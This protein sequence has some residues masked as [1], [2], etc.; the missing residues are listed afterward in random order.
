MK[1]GIRGHDLGKRENGLELAKAAKKANF[2]SMQLVLHKALDGVSGESSTL[3][4]EF[5]NQIK[6]AFEQNNIEIIMLGAYFNIIEG[7]KVQ[8]DID[9]FKEHL[10]LAKEFG[11]SIVG[12]ET[13]SYSN[14]RIYDHRTNTKEAYDTVLKVVREL[15]AVAE[16][17]D[18]YVAIEAAWYH[19]IS[20]CKLVKKLLDDIHSN[21]LKVI[22]DLFNLVN[23]DNYKKQREIIDEAF[24]LYGEKIVLVHAKD[25]VVNG[26]ALKQ[27]PLGE[28]LYDYD[29]LIKK[30]AQEKP[31]M[32]IIFEGI[33]GENKIN[34]SY[35]FIKNKVEK[36]T[37]K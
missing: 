29:Y 33:T 24:D 37:K 9:K 11:C 25:F 20:N 36:Y 1:I 8:A 4:K 13:G 17:N 2:T 16:E 18:V 31:H 6:V 27:V 12:S 22:F 23:I 10:K 35:K 3:T 26:K 5:A 30:L 21:H 28:G 14:G 34:N 15:V 7:K 19:V 32:T